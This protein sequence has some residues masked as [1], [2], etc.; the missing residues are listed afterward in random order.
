MTIAKSRTVSDEL[1]VPVSTFRYAVVWTVF[2]VMFVTLIARAVYLQVLDTERLQSEGDLRYLRVQ[3]ELPNRGMILDR[4][5]RPLA[6]STPVDTITM[7]PATL[8]A[9]PRNAKLGELAKLLKINEKR[10]IKTAKAKL[11]KELVYLKRQISPALAKQILALDID[12]IN[13]MR[14]YKRYYPS[15]P[16]LSHVIG[17]TNIDD[18]GQAGLE[19]AYDDDL[20]GHAGRTRVLKDRKGRVIE[21]VEQLSAVQHGKNVQLSLDSRIQYL[22]YRHLEA[23]VER[24]KASTA[25]LVALDAKTGEVLAMVGFPH[26]N[27]NDVAERKN[28][29]TRNRSIADTFEP[30]STVKPFAVAMSMD[31]GMVTPETVISTGDGQFYIGRNK[32]SDTKKMGDISVSTVIQKS[33]NIG[34]TKVAMMLEPIDLYKT[35][36]SLGF[37][38]AN[39]LR[40]P[41]E[42][43]GLLKRRKKWRP[44]EHATLSYG[45]GLSVNTLQLARS[46]Q[47]L[48]ND[49]L[50]LPVSLHPVANIPKARRVFTSDTVQKVN[51]ML[52]LAAGD[53]G[54]AP[55]AQVAMYRVAGKT[56]TAH[57]VVNGKYQDDSY[58]S[59]FAGFAPVSDPEIV[60]VIAVSDPQGVDYYGGLVAA[61][62]FSKVMEG[63]LRFRNVQ[64]DNL[65]ND[66]VEK[67]APR[68]IISRPAVVD[69]RVVS[70]SHMAGGEG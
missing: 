45:Y 4:D 32:V 6:V 60:M 67:S 37:G 26:F 47:A 27:P 38:Q 25:S 13:T 33:S 57:R 68:L 64:P 40:L 30:G 7:R 24:H 11:D 59:L 48:A 31:A 3:K 66:R 42:N 70:R 1:L 53:G 54:T 52:E 50:M 9:E 22:A 16:V 12:G 63:A 20:K 28:Q 41:G 61:P 10:L 18:V 35:Y 19:L 58:T 23:A 56:G 17:F 29:R 15:G 34:V 46:Y 62:V 65:L 51:R 2:A 43:K 14:E 36:R 69:Q 5:G 49:G 8:L 44:I 55:N 39:Q 21:H